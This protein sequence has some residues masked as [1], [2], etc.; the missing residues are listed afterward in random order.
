M[1]WFLLAAACISAGS[2]D[3]AA[4]ISAGPAEPFLT[5]IEPVH[6][7]DTSLPPGHSLGLSE[8]ST[9]FP[10]LSDLENSISSFSEME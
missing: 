6:A 7:D 3:P 10:S 1:I 5:V 2:S 9:R 8:H 4:S